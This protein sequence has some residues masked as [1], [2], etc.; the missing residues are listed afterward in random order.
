MINTLKPCQSQTEH[1]AKHLGYVVVQ[2]HSQLA[3]VTCA[4]QS[5]AY[6]SSCAHRLAASRY[7]G[8]GPQTGLERS[9]RKRRRCAS[10]SACELQKQRKPWSRPMDLMLG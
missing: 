5:E 1:G 8:K 4:V 2:L 3:K 10:T 7:M 6:I 9:T